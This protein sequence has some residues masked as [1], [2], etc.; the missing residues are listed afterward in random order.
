VTGPDSPVDGG[1][2]PGA[3]SVVVEPTLSGRNRLTTA[4]RLIL[5]APHWIIL[6]GITAVGAWRGTGALAEAAIAMVVV[7]WFAILFTGR[8]P[9]GLWLFARYYLRWSLRVGAYAALLRDE[10]PPFGDGDYP[11]S[12]EV[13][14]PAEPRD[15]LRVFLRPVLIIPQLVVLI[16]VDVA[17][18]FSTI[19][20]WFSI[21]F[22]GTLPAGLARF[23]AGALR[24]NT[25]VQAYGLL[26]TDAYPPFSLS[27]PRE[28][29]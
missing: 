27:D 14:A 2:A 25:R 3:V 29:T 16:F 20:A 22:S 6:G 24:W 8:A 18:F 13:V 7:A 19:L 17:W 26:L 12:V 4:F 23:G 28:G 5:L 11:A 21:L 15:R 9:H 10:Y 1:G